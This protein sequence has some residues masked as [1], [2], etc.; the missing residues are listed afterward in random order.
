MCSCKTFYIKKQRDRF[1]HVTYN[2]VDL[3]LAIFSLG[4]SG[5]SLALVASK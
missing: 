4:A 1:K 5:M 2:R 3:Y